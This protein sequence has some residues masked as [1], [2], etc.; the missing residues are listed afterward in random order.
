MIKKTHKESIY[1]RESFCKDVIH[2]EDFK[3]FQ[4]LYILFKI[5][6]R[7]LSIAQANK[8]RTMEGVSSH[9]VEGKINS[10]VLKVS[11]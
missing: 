6:D 2:Y 10:L 7:M 5:N 8:L 11:C 3:K 4:L 9:V 1:V